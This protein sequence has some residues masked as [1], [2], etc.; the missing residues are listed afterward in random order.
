MVPLDGHLGFSL[1]SVCQQSVGWIHAPFTT[2]ADI[3]MFLMLYPGL[4]TK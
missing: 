4:Q 1:I 2:T 3:K